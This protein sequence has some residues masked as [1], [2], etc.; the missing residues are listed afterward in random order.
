MSDESLLHPAPEEIERRPLS[1]ASRVLLGGP[2]ALVTSSW[3][4]RP[5]VMPLAW[6]M[7]VS[8]DPP[9]LAIAIEQS[10]YSIDVINHS[11][12]FVLNFPKR[13][14]LH[15]VQYLGAISGEQIDKLEAAQMNYFGAARV[16]APLIEGCAAWIE[17]GVRHQLPFGDHVLYIAEVLAVHVDPAS[18]DE[19]WRTETGDDRP[20]L[21]LG[22]QT[23][24]TLDRAQEARAPR[25][26]DAPERVLAERM[27]EELE[28]TA[29]AKE[30]RAELRARLEDEV[31]RG[32]VVDIDDLAEEI[33]LDEA[34]RLDLSSGIALGDVDEG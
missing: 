5:N 26:L 9:L 30:R 17:C 18:F 22:G 34:D 4:G 21:F 20:L 3:R 15:H 6:H 2:V 13:P 1:T 11:E 14:L 16:T 8:A 29:E 25:D 7:P 33:D 19:H 32:N 27:A 28:L 24:S 12:E 31:A 23:Y 10:R